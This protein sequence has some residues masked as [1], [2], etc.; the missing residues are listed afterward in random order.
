MAYDLK[1]LMALPDEEKI[2]L[3]NT[4]WDSIGAENT[5]DL[6]KEEIEFLDQR[7]KEYEANPDEGLAWDEVKAKLKEKYGF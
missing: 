1:E 5:T 4:L 3:A 7:L 6:T 2:I